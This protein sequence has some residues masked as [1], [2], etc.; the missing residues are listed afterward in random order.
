M[1]PGLTPDR[2]AGHE[3]LTSP[4]C[5][6]DRLWSDTRDG[7]G[8]RHERAHDGEISLQFTVVSPTKSLVANIVSAAVTTIMPAVVV[9]CA[10][11]RSCWF[12]PTRHPGG[13]D[14]TTAASSTPTK[15]GGHSHLGTD[16]R[17]G[18]WPTPGRCVAGAGYC[19]GSKTSTGQPP[20]SSAWAGDC[21]GTHGKKH[22]R[23]P[24]SISAD[25]RDSES[26]PNFAS[27]GTV[28]RTRTG[29]VVRATRAR[30]PRGCRLGAALV[31]TCGASGERRWCLPA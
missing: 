15:P 26:H 9:G 23:H 18:I 16:C 22:H 8:R 11:A 12:G 30:P 1:Y 17:S 7:D 31:S 14:P 2:S 27:G 19:T 4:I 28:S 24:Q 5:A 3:A 21:T 29:A 20:R 13:V 10:N 25:S 6:T